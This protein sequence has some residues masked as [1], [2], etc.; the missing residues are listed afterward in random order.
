MP[1]R[2][3][4]TLRPAGF[5]G[6]PDGVSWEYVEWPTM[7]DFHRSDIPTSQHLYGVIETDR[8]LTPEELRHYDIEPVTP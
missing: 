7:M 6:V 3:R 4:T 2:Y 8:E 5:G 1:K